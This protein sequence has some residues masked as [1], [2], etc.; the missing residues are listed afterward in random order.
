[1]SKL[2]LGELLLADGL[3]TEE[4]FSE[5][6]E[7]QKHNPN[8]PIGQVICQLGFL[9]VEELNLA[10][11]FNK[12]RLRLGDILIKQKLIDQAKLDRAL[13]FSKKEQLQLGKAL[14]RLRYIQEEQ[15]AKAIAI[16]YDLKYVSLDKYELHESAGKLFSSSYAIRNRI[17]AIEK[18]ATKVTIAMAYPLSPQIQHEL[19]VL[20]RL[21]IKPVIARESEI[22]ST[23][24]Y[25]YGIKR[26]NKLL[27]QEDQVKLDILEDFSAESNRSNYLLDYNVDYLTKR[28]ISVGARAGAS[29]IHLEHTERGAVVRF[30]IDGVLQSLDLGGD[31]QQVLLHGKPLVSKLKILCDLDI[32]EKRRPQNG[33]FRV[34]MSLSN[35]TKTIDFRVSTL[36]TKYGE[37]VVIRILDRTGVMSLQSLGFSPAI[38]EELNQLLAKPTG[39]FLVTGPTGSGKSST[40]YAILNKL[41][42]P[43]AKTLTVEDPIEYIMDGISQ[44]EVNAAIG[45]TFAEHLRAFLRQDPDHIMVGEIRDI[46]TALI[47][48]R[49]SLTGHTVLS[50]LHTNDS[51]SVVQRLVDMGVE[52]T[53]LSATLRCII[54]QRLVRIICEH[55]SEERAPSQEL[56]VEFGISPEAFYRFRWGKGCSYCNNTG[57]SG[58]KPIVEMWV[59]SREE[60]LLI[61]K[62]ASN[63][64]MRE[65]AF[66]HSNRAT[67]VEDGLLK[68]F[69]GETT[70]EELA[71]VVPYEQ[72]VEYRNKL[73]TGMAVHC[74]SAP[75][76]DLGGMILP[77]GINLPATFEQP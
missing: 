16:Q 24:E 45:N 64:T 57:F 67:M 9:S 68:V 60:A 47:S 22:L 13:E 14:L 31:S 8:M 7:T 77:V 19:E 52:P 54:S 69:N 27:P 3:L 76:L 35:I 15:L 46:D 28:L 56:L 1:M 70:L 34:K 18:T 58:R 66:C 12:K 61:N 59:P 44:S 74:S 73:K 30:R 23:L 11:D 48:I 40:L 55:C 50:T 43:G 41:N 65:S 32:T 42:Q 51:T 4:Q 71:R 6:L 21:T 75:D 26:K 37:N 36:P 17:I 5:A 10:L 29:D 63:L 53:L 62:H 2:R 39:I 33:S 49:A 72:V 20:I 38:T 25:I